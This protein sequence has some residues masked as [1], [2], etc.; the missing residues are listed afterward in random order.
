MKNVICKNKAYLL[1]KPLST[2]QE[3]TKIRPRQMKKLILA[4]GGH[5]HLAVLRHLARLRPD[6]LSV[7]LVTPSA[8]QR[9]SGM[10]P[11]WIAGTYSLSEMSV[12]LRPLCVAAGVEMIESAVVGMDADRR[13]VV[14]PDDRHL[15][16]DLLSL[17]I[18][19]ET[20][21]S[22]FENVG[23]RLLPVK[24]LDGFVDAWSTWIVKAHRSQRVH[25]VVVGGGAAGF[26]LTMAV[27]RAMR[28][29][30]RVDLDLIAGA[31]GLLPEYGQAV[32]RRASRCLRD[33]GA[34]IH[35]QRAVG[36]P[37]G[38]M[39]ANGRDFH[40]DIVLVATGARAPCWLKLSK[41]TLDERGHVAV[42]A[43]HRSLSHRQVFA[44]GDIC[45]RMDVEM[46]RS[47]VHAVHAGP[48]L[49]H[50]LT[51]TLSN[52]RLRAYQPRKTSLYLLANGERSAIASWGGY[53]AEGRWVWCWKDAIDR[54]FI[55]R[56]RRQAA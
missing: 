44:S 39:L 15:E 24:P 10:L 52:E 51:A 49:A 2:Q 47:G 3:S 33:A 26:E 25:I 6:G 5:A 4:G 7:T 30:K 27:R 29:V 48:V 50:N 18:G 11:G 1:D 56:H 42:D 40:P 45:T 21:C 23:P 36:I 14:L 41:L 9:Y 31:S 8:Y 37:G 54:R 55:A 13:C 16:Y 38:V 46:A 17:G 43:F 20:D 19:A 22:W 35:E 34:V 32:R 53:S 28:D 12:D